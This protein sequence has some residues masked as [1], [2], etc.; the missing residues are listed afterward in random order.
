MNNSMSAPNA[1]QRAMA[2]DLSKEQRFTRML[3]SEVFPLLAEKHGVTIKV[4][5]DRIMD[6]RGVDVLIDNA[7][8]DIKAHQLKSYESPRRYSFERSTR[9]RDFSDGKDGRE[10]TGVRD[11]WL[12]SEKKI[13]EKYM[14]CYYHV[15]DQ[16]RVTDVTTM[17]VARDSILGLIRD[18]G[19]DPTA[20]YEN[21]RKTCSRASLRDNG[22]LKY[23]WNDHPEVSMTL[24]KQLPEQPL[25]FIISIDAIQRVCD[26]YETIT[27]ATPVEW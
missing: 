3:E 27:L 21:L 2:N 23:W 18:C 4:I 11:G 24:S 5:N 19:I 26:W 22:S 13:T 8:V 15:D 16:N 6:M 17:L 1:L 12:I 25:N 10:L 9:Y 7:Y 20:D 14:I